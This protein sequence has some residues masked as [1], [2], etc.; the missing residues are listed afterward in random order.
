MAC[1]LHAVKVTTHR[2]SCPRGETSKEG[3]AG[4]LDRIPGQIF[5]FAMKDIVE[6][7]GKT[8]LRNMN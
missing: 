1:V 7:V 4:L 8:L 5:F 2:L 6:T 3:V